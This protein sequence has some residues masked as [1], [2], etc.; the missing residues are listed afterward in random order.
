MVTRK[1]KGTAKRL[2]SQGVS[3]Y[4]QK[5]FLKAIDKWK[6]ANAVLENLSRSLEI[7]GEI[8]RTDEYIANAWIA[9]DRREEALR[10]YANAKKNY[11]RVE[12]WPQW[13]DIHM[14]EGHI[15]FELRD[16]NEALSHYQSA[17]E[18]YLWIKNRIDHFRVPAEV[19]VG[20]RRY[21]IF[22]GMMVP[23]EEVAY[24]YQVIFRKISEAQHAIGTTLCQ[25][26]LHNDAIKFGES[27][28]S[29]CQSQGI[30]E[31]VAASETT[32]GNAK[33]GL[34]K[35]ED[36]LEHLENARCFYRKLDLPRDVAR[37]EANIGAT[38][39]ALR[40]PAEAMKRYKSALKILDGLD[41]IIDEAKVYYSRALVRLVQ[42]PSH[43][44]KQVLRDLDSSY[45]LF[46]RV[47][48]GVRAPRFR[49]S[50]RKEYINVSESQ[51]AV[52]LLLYKQTGN[53]QCLKNAL[54]CI[55][56]AKCSTVAESLEMGGGGVPCPKATMLVSQEEKFLK[57]IEDYTA[58]EQILRKKRKLK[59]ITQ[60]EFSSNI[61]DMKR[62]LRALYKKVKELR[63]EVSVRCADL[64]STPLSRKYEVLKRALEVF[65]TDEKWCILEFAILIVA[66]EKRIEDAAMLDIDQSISHIPLTNKMV[67]FLVDQDGHIKHK[68]HD[69]DLEDVWKLA[70]HC[71]SIF[72]KLH[73]P[74]TKRSE[75]NK[76]LDTLSKILYATLVPEEIGEAVKK[77]LKTREDENKHLIIVPDKFLNWVP[78]ELLFDGDGYWGL[79]YAIST[80]FS[81]DLA[82]LCV[83]KRR[84]M[85]RKLKAG[86]E[87]KD[88]SYFLL[89]KNPLFD[90][91]VAEK[92]VDNIVEMLKKK[93][94]QYDV[95]PHKKATQLAFANRVT[96]K[97]LSVLHYV[98]HAKFMG[99]DPALSHL[100]LHTG[101]KGECKACYQRK[102]EG[103]VVDPLP[104]T[105][106]I[107]RVKFKGSPIVY[108]SACETG[109][110]DVEPGDEMFGLV[111]ALM[112][113]GATTLILSR[114]GVLEMPARIFAIEFYKHL[115]EGESTAVALRNAR[116]IVYKRKRCSFIDW[117]SFSLQGDPFRTLT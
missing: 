103:H 116:K 95:L 115:L 40:K 111:R 5:K 11:R 49:R 42:D 58:N 67:V 76:E 3:F 93:G 55:E 56:L 46:E 114:W 2:I 77:C 81:L 75:I 102:K 30:W 36:A 71:R 98:G 65:P 24:G 78:F 94:I 37:A 106:F 61:E 51:C 12:M 63:F 64:G 25:K 15:L 72:R 16:Y 53:E 112:Y 99:A 31:G 91:D 79:K 22:R 1:Q 60:S 110:A 62:K 39:F 104:A 107:Q 96:K 88:S 87:L 6:A 54:N 105:E 84:E 47:L 14:N 70:E 82:R 97:P 69:V 33:R 4:E 45:G 35:P 34:N 43:N 109:I 85:A 80:D 92:G 108:L 48:M 28:K 38:L 20:E 101:K 7:L 100:L 10:S 68:V 57:E 52:H 27:T 19:K 29:F 86:A 74:T 13:A 73:I 83:Q 90:L 59:E 26:G 23:K 32:I 21:E 17:L 117:A 66:R 89:V 50:L 18:R 41:L 44:L 9:L 113:A 8:A